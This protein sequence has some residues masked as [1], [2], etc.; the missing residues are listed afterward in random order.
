M[1]ILFHCKEE[2][3]DYVNELKNCTL[4]N[5][6]DPNTGEV[7]IILDIDPKINQEL[8]FQDFTDYFGLDYDEVNCIEAYNFCA[9]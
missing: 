9:V 2:V 8:D 5:I 7:D 3:L 1:Q 6:N 4:V